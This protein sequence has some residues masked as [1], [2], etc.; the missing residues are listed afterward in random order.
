MVRTDK[1]NATGTQLISD[2]QVIDITS[3]SAAVLS[4]V[5]GCFFQVLIPLLR[6]VLTDD[7]TVI[8]RHFLGS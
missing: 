8:G 7:F 2:L 4:I 3:I 1:T 5:N 6:V